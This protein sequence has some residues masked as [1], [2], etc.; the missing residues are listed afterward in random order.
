MP[1]QALAKMP[2]GAVM[3]DPTKCSPDAT[4]PANGKTCTRQCTTDCGRG[5]YPKVGDGSDSYDTP[6]SWKCTLCY[7]RAGA[8]ADLNSAY[9]NPLPTKVYPDA[10]G[11]YISSISG[12]SVPDI[13][14]QPSCVFTCPAKA[15]IWDTKDNI[16][17]T[18]PGSGYLNDP[19]NGFISA[20]GDGSI[21]WASRKNL[22]IAPKADPF[23]EDHV[24]PLV[25]SVISGPYAKA[26]LLPTILAGGLVAVIAR[27]QQLAGPGI[28][29]V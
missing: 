4:N 1:V 18:V 19:K 20:Q 13:K 2:N 26:A 15:M 23:I 24:T 9:G 21:Y 6:K 12:T 22:L 25:S 27:R 3:I 7:G 14:H 29:E 5:G 8:D 17:G 16:V 28:E 11:N 10:D